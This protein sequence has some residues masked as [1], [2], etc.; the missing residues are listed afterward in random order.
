MT[1]PVKSIEQCPMG[2][3]I[4]IL[5]GKWKIYILW[6]LRNGAVRFNELQRKLPR[7]TQKTLT[8]QLRELEMDGIIVRQVYPEVPPRVEYSLSKLG[9]SIKPL[10]ASMCKWGIYYQKV[11]TLAPKEPGEKSS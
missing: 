2:V 10:L 4:K 1:K 6:Y 3:S 7:I 9:E 11:R 8:Q 5:S